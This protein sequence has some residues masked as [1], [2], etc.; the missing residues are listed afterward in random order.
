MINPRAYTDK[1]SPLFDRIQ[2]SKNSPPAWISWDPRLF[3]ASHAEYLTL[4]RPPMDGNVRLKD[5]YDKSL[6]NYGKS[7]NQYTDI[8]DGQIT[9]YVNKSRSNP[10]YS[11]LF[12]QPAEQVSAIYVDPM[13]SVKPE[14]TR[15]PIVDTDNPMTSTRNEFQYNLSFIEDSQS[16][17]EDLL[18]LQMR[19]RNAQRWM[20]RWENN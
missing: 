11:P 8:N 16:H 1:Q 2:C 17:R 12:A 5:I 19:Q 13:G 4:D 15:N 3:S 10:F 18:A 7:S 20:P 9:Y 6:T 14:Y